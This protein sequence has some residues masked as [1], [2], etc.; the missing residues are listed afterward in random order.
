MK[1]SILVVGLLAALLT[2]AFGQGSSLRLK[3]PFEFVAGGKTLPAGNY[4]FSVY[5]N[6]V[7]MKS[8][9][10]RETLSLTF[11]TRIAGDNTANGKARISF[12][13]QE[14]KH[15][16]EAIWPDQDDG[17]LVHVVKGEHTHEI[18]RSQ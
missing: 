12:D 15:F 10:T 9:D 17:Y 2:T 13:V 14:G 1:R 6:L 5:N 11:L 3:I 18:V 8:L 16:I 7:Q 4:Q